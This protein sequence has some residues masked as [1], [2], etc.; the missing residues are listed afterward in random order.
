MNDPEFQATPVEIGGG[1]N[2]LNS[3]SIKC[4]SNL[5]PI[6]ALDF[7]A[8]GDEENIIK[9][10]KKSKKIIRNKKIQIAGGK[11]VESLGLCPLNCNS[12]VVSR[13][14]CAAP[15]HRGHWS[16]KRPFIKIKFYPFVVDGFCKMHMFESE[17]EQNFDMIPHYTEVGINEFVID[18]LAIH[19]T[20]CQD[21]LKI[22][23]AL[24]QISNNG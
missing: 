21:C 20:L 22:F 18:F 3:Y 6:D 1:I 8:L 9:C 17:I 7:S 11:R 19:S 12:A 14:T 10:I 24:C 4:L 23:S 15:C 2:L 13:L 16:V 5:N